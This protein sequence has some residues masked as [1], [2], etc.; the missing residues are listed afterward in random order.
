MGWN[1]HQASMTVFD[2]LAAM[3]A[4]MIT[5]ASTAANAAVIVHDNADETFQWKRSVHIFG[6]EDIIGTFLDITQPPTQSGTLV[7]GSFGRW[8][9]PNI[10]GSEPGL[11]RIIST[12]SSETARTTGSIKLY[13]NNQ[14]IFVTPTREYTPSELV[15]SDANWRSAST[16]FYHNPFSDDFVNGAPAI[17]SLAYV[18]VRIIESEGYRYGW[19]LLEDYTKPV[20]WAYETQIGV[21]IQI[22]VPGPGVASGVLFALMSAVAPRRRASIR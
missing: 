17:S 5:L 10:T 11:S 22:P 12:G 9:Y 4:G 14:D 2:L 16:Y 18:G 6:S 3:L 8:Y 19:I 7:S 15:I 1:R 21:P 20:M 13:W